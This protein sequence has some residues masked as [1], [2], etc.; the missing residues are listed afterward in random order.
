M[1]CSKDKNAVVTKPARFEWSDDF[2]K[3]NL[4]YYNKKIHE[5]AFVLPTWAD[6]VLNQD[7]RC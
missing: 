5:A 7:W 4:K 1:V 6:N 3:K 2:V